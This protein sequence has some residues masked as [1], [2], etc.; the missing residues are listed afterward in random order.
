MSNF[1]VLVIAASAVTFVASGGYTLT[2]REWYDP[3]C[4]IK[5]NV[6]INSGERIYHVTGQENYDA[7][8][9]SSQHGERWFC[10]EE[11]ARTAGWRKAGR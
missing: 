5:G 2:P 11:D 10:S 7:T 1:T 8:R 4:N 9:I 3:S 6:S